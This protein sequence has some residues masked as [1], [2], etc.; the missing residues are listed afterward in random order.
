MV[1]FHFLR[2]LADLGFYYAFAGSVAAVFG[3][4]YA[5]AGLVLQGL[6]FAVSSAL[7]KKRFLALLPMLLFFLLPEL[8]LADIIM[9]IFPLAYTAYITISKDYSLRWDR[10]AD[11]FSV[12][13]KAYVIFCLFAAGIGHWD[14]V[15]SGGLS[16][17]FIGAVSS[18]LLMR[19]LRHDP[20]VYLERSFQMI[21]A[22]SVAALLVV[23]L[24]ASS[25]WFLES[26]MF[27][28][29]LLFKYVAAP[30][31][32]CVLMAIGWVCTLIMPDSV[33]VTTAWDEVSELLAGMSG[34]E[35][36]LETADKA[37]ASSGIVIKFLTALAVIGALLALYVFFRWLIKKRDT[38]DSAYTDEEIRIDYAPAENT[39]RRGSGSVRR[40]RNEYRSFLKYC[41]KQGIPLRSADTSTEISS[42]AADHVPNPDAMAELQVIYQKARYHNEATPED[43]AKAKSLLGRI[44]RK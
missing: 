40:I 39:K 10:Q 35:A 12:F 28:T 43:A 14:A 27:I 23:T 15:R 5:L 16:S 33:R 4:S 26:V 44:K 21:N 11:V 3:G 24:A 2:A 31:I 29:R 32:W 37:A 13:W 6:C 25:Q 30:I 34:E 20:E 19:S 42:R 9:Y 18:I 1:I 17:G 22:V 7:G 41:E 38:S 36:E 8:S